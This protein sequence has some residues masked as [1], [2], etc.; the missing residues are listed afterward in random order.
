MEPQARHDLNDDN[1]DDHDDDDNDDN[2]NN[3][4]NNNNIK[5]NKKEFFFESIKC[6]TFSEPQA[7]PDLNDDDDHYHD[8]DG[9]ESEA[10]EQ[11]I[12]IP[13]SPRKIGL[14]LHMG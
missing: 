11:F 2:N 10:P 3:E 14:T 7:R 1:D 13:P 4:D 12:P 8:D 5:D 9:N 6:H